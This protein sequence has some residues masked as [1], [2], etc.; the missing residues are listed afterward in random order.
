MIGADLLRF[1]DKQQYCFFDEETYSLNLLTDN[2]PW[3][4]SSILATKNEI[5]EE[6]DHFINWGGRFHMSRDAARITGYSE[7][8]VKLIGKDPLEVWNH[9]EPLLL[10]DDI[11]LC[12]HNVLFFDLY[13]INQW[14]RYLGK[15]PI[16]NIHRVLDTN[17]VAR[18]MKLGI[19]PD[20]AHFIQQ[21]YA[22]G[23]LSREKRKGVKTSL[24][25]LAKE[26]GIQVDDSKLHNSIYDLSIN[27]Q[28]LQKLL[29]AVEI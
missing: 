24:G 23:T 21:Q 6:Q 22:M 17:A 8:K 28:V 25:V 5:I 18:M 1:N 11:I 19:K 13:I 9:F 20:R 27:L 29:W 10:N 7:E 12:G 4:H 14:A 15:R 3:Q 2:P 26:F 16:Y